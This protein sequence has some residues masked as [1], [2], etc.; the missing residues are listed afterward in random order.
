M[1]TGAS[2]PP[3]TM[4]PASIMSLIWNRRFAR[5]LPKRSSPKFTKFSS[6]TGWMAITQ[7]ILAARSMKVLDTNVA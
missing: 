2:V 4:S 5:S 1:H 7:G 3:A 6:H